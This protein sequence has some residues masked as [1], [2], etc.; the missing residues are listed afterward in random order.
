[1]KPKKI[2]L[3]QSAQRMIGGQLAAHLG[4]DA[5][6]VALAVF[7][8]QISHG[9]PM[10]LGLL[11]SMAFVPNILFGIAV[12]GFIE[13]FHKKRLLILTNLVRVFVILSIPLFNSLSWAMI[14]MF[15]I[16]LAST[17]NRPTL[18]SLQ[19]EAA[20]STENLQIM[21][22]RT[23]QYFA[24]ADFFA[25][26][27]IGA[28]VLTSGYTWGFIMDS[29]FYLIA[30]GFL[31]SIRLPEETWQPPLAANHKFS[32]QVK[33]GLSYYK[34]HNNVT[35][36]AILTFLIMTVI[37][38]AN[39]LLAPS[40]RIYWHQPTA[41]YSW[42]L[43][44]LVVGNLIAARKIEKWLGKVPYSRLLII[45]CISFAAELSVLPFTPT[46]FVGMIVGVTMGFSNVL[47]NAS[48]ITWIMTLVNAT[49]R[50]RVL[51]IRGILMGLGGLLGSIGAGWVARH[52]TLTMAYFFV[53]FMIVISALFLL[54]ALWAKTFKD[55]EEVLTSKVS[56]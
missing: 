7:A 11:L 23:S 19:P 5:T 28:V 21:V 16:H 30:V 54:V 48:V 13:R 52:V 29:A 22:A 4:D 12:A 6:E 20:G 10:S 17:F 50:G 34:N 44:S 26:L 14:A 37:S 35:V 1:M 42:M 32:T 51:A 8:L 41:H 15:L 36:L 46:I 40:A 53:A 55:E 43:L 3:P 31:A 9:S 33:E 56:S 39:V 45:G 27:G 18:R 25:Y 47:M 2:L 38:G 24:I 49:F